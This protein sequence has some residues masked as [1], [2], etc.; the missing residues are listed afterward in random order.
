MEK[1]WT[2]NELIEYISN[3]GDK[4]RDDVMKQILENDL[5][6]K[7]LSTSE[8]RLIMGYVIDSI[9]SNVMKIVNL[10]SSGKEFKEIEKAAIDIS[11][12]YNFMYKLA[13]IALKGKMHTEGIGK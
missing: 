2:N 6:N 13:D 10:A 4:R 5:L 12:S 9:T 3:F 1:T 7:F 11:L 8:G